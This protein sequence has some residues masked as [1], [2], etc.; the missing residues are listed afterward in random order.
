MEIGHFLMGCR[1]SVEGPSQRGQGI[2]RE[3]RRCGEQC[4]Y[5]ELCK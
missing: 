3:C 1:P 2:G 5:W 4:G